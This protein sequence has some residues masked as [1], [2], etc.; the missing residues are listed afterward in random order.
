M[1]EPCGPDGPDQDP[2][3]IADDGQQE[4]IDFYET[5]CA[6]HHAVVNLFTAGVFHLFEQQVGTLLEDWNRKRPKFPF[7][8]LG[9][10][11]LEDAAGSSNAVTSAPMWAKLTGMIVTRHKRDSP[12]F[13][14]AR[15]DTEAIDANVAG[16]GCSGRPS[17]PR[18]FSL[19]SYALRA[20][21]ARRPVTAPALARAV[22]ERALDL[23]LVYD[24]PC[25][26]RRLTL[27]GARR[28]ARVAP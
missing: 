7:D 18:S 19:T 12:E 28:S 26:C 14:P 3:D 15:D 9:K 6:M 13:R 27:A 20:V 24:V 23:P 17:H 2:G 21:G 1:S 8:E 25:V 5:I 22:P 16:R 10:L 11:S 4:S